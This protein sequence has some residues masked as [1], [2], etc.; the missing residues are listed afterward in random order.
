MLN[1][2]NLW[3]RTALILFVVGTA[4]L[5]IPPYKEYCDNYAADEKYCAAYEMTVA[6]GSF[7]DAHNGAVSAIATIFIA[8]FTWTV[9][10]STDKLWRATQRSATIA[11]RALKELEAPFISI[12]ITDTGITR[13]YGET[14]HVFTNIS[15]CI[16]NHGRTPARILELVDKFALIGIGEGNPPEVRTDAATRNTMPYGV[17]APPN[18]E[19]QPFT[20]NLYAFMIRNDLAIDPLPLTTKR[21]FFYGFVRYATIFDEVFRMGFCCI[22]DVASEKWLLSGGGNHNYCC[23]ERG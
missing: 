18:G 1:N 11:E 23:K 17:I 15:F 2:R 3:F 21:I 9:R 16:P 12:K 20:N 5:L 7:F 8:A 14:G 13:T 19:S 22:F 4:F 10:Q 6:F